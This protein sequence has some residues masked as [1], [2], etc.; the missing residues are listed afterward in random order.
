MI[1]S[2]S[3]TPLIILTQPLFAQ[4]NNW[5]A[6]AVGLIT[7]H[8]VPLTTPTQSLF[9]V[10]EAEPRKRSNAFGQKERPRPQIRRRSRSAR[11]Q[12]ARSSLKVEVP[13]YYLRWSGLNSYHIFE[14]KVSWW[15]QVFTQSA[16]LYHRS[17]NFHVKNNLHEKCSWC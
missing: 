17:G 3:R 14:V 13:R 7:I 15:H 5:N 1:N 6:C 4:L 9:D 8:Y 16:R 11:P 10:L 12:S 2:P